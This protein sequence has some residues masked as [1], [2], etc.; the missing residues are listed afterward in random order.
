MRNDGQIDRGFGG[1]RRRMPSR[2]AL[3]EDDRLL[4]V[5]PNR[6]GG[7][8]KYIFGLTLKYSAVT[9]ALMTPSMRPRMKPHA[10]RSAGL[11]H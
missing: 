7:Q 4:T 8:T 3:H 5:A 2:S 6:S 1:H 10:F 9:W 11:A